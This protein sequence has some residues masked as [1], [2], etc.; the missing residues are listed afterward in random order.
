[1]IQETDSGGGVVMR[2][3]ALAFAA[4]GL[5]ALMLM[6]LF[7]WLIVSSIIAAAGG[8]DKVDELKIGDVWIQLLGLMSVGT[9][10]TMVVA[11]CFSLSGTMLQ[12]EPEG[13]P[14]K[15]PLMKVLE[16]M[17][18]AFGAS[19]PLK[20]KEYSAEYS[21]QEIRRE[22]KNDAKYMIMDIMRLDE[23]ARNTPE[24]KRLLANAIAVLEE[25]DPEEDDEESE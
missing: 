20:Y 7:A 10:G 12:P 8:V 15:K 1:M 14:L 11:Q 18:S 16:F 5:F 23:S 25:D 17:G 2:W 21:A 22:N 3:N 6:L 24:A 4:M 13:N 19:Q 9:M